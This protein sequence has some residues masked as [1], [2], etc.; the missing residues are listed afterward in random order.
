MTFQSLSGD[1]NL[2][3]TGSYYLEDFTEINATKSSTYEFPYVSF[4]RASDPP[5]H[6]LAEGAALSHEHDRW[7][8]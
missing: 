3:G 8:H 6:P 1:S 7:R 5:G 4:F 2:Q